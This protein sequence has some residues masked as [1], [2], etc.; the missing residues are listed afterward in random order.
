MSSQKR[1]P[2]YLFRAEAFTQWR[3]V[4]RSGRKGKRKG[5]KSKHCAAEKESD[6]ETNSIRDPTGQR[7]RQD[8]SGQRPNPPARRADEVAVFFGE[9]DDAQ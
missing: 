1:A 5:G 9:R 4:L 7:C 3:F 6:A 2:F 8:E